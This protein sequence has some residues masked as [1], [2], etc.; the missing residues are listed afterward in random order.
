MSNIISIN[1][2]GDS[3]TM[4]SLELVQFINNQR[5]EGEPI[6]AHSDF[7]KK[8]PQVLG[9]D[10]G[11]FSS[12]YLD[13]MNREKPCY[14]F[15]KREACLMAMSYSYDLQ[16]KVFD[17]MT[18]LEAQAEAMGRFNLPKT[19]SEAMRLAADEMEKREVLE[20]KLA[21]VAPKVAVHDRIAD[22]E[23]SISIREAANTLRVPERKFVLWLQQHDWCYRRAG[24]KSLLGYAEK[25]KAGYLYLKQTPIRDVHTGE[26][27][28]SEQVRITPLGLTVL[29]KRFT[30]DPDMPL[31]AGAQ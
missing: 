28:L 12:I 21:L 7:L 15:P 9:E 10:A 26:E 25:V 19:Y 5:D 27:R 24:H 1:G 22:A 8:V 6:L 29:A 14:T 3:V 31:Q 11:N 20:T 2:P 18:M 17:R 4:T 16:A 23:G 30:D 13:S